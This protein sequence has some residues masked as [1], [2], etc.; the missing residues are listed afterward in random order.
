MHRIIFLS[1]TFT[2]LCL[3]GMAQCD[4]ASTANGSPCSQQTPATPFCADENPYG[5]TYP[6]ST[7]SPSS[8]PFTGNTHVDCCYTTPNPAW[9]YF[10]IDQA[11]TLTIHI[12]QHSY[13]G[14]GLDVD[15]VCWGPFTA[16]SQ[17]DFTNQL[18]CGQL[19]INNSTVV[20]CSYSAAAVED[21]NFGNVQAGQWYLLLLTNYSNQP[22]TITFNSTSNSTAST[23]CDLLN[24]G[25]S[26]SPI[27]EG[28]TLE[29]YV[30][31]PVT[32]ATYNWTGPNGFAQS[33]TN[34]TLQVPNVTTNMSGE[35][36]MTMTGISQNSNTAVVDVLITP[37]PTPEIIAEREALCLG[38]S[39][40]LSVNS[41]YELFWSA[42][43]FSGNYS[44]VAEYVNTVTVSPTESTHYILKV[45][46]DGCVGRDT[47]DIIVNP[48]PVI[49]ITIADPT[50]CYG[51]GTNI[52]ATGGA[53]YNW[54][55]GS[56]SSTIH[57][58]PH[59]TTTYSVEVKTEAL[60]SADTTI[61]I[62]VYPELLG[63][64]SVEPSY[65]GQATGEITM[66]ATGG[67]GQYTFT[68]PGANFN[69][70]VASHLHAGTYSIT[71]TD[72]VG[73]HISK[74]TEISSVP[75]PT[76]C[77][78]FA[79]SDDVNMVITNCTQGDNTFFWDFGDGVTSTETH[80][81]HEYM[82]PGRYSVSMIVSDEH[83]CI[84]SLRQDYV[85]NGPV[86]IANAFSPNGDGI[87]DEIC[88]IGKTIQK[89]EFFWA[90]Y[91]RHGS[92]VFSSYN[93][94]ICWDGT[95]PNGKEVVPG[96]YVYRIKYRDVNGNYF[97]RD[98]NI[99]LI[100]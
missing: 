94:E 52:T 79:T 53:H 82:D 3:S 78:I 25:D 62:I 61:E 28:Q 18:C 59:Q 86:Y 66:T 63:S 36:Q 67:M 73:C 95:L 23:N 47:I 14:A 50:L 51:D 34:T 12:E 11:G 65:C 37:R 16:A 32:G 72:S 17:A 1:L 46:N 20:D 68:A 6:S 44:S 30:T 22:G 58:S 5:I 87:N 77:F 71:I 2:V 70:N 55:N 10:Q 76:P 42:V 64:Y 24:S 7:N 75:G 99:T 88:I 60:C 26:N 19:N 31:A 89:Q 90:I 93:P 97:E 9:Y 38:E 84:D 41:N 15:F 54:S 91:D 100:R 35:Y 33:T 39:T 48:N 56:T 49:G 27:C 92:L 13:S 69:D 85:I 74:E 43:T 8:E 98:G 96:V 57:V 21:C 4:P 29:L 81:V 80:P 83:N 40:Q 45:D